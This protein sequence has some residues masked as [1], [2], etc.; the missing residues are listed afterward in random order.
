MSRTGSRLRPSRHM[1]HAVELMQTDATRDL[2][3]APALLAGC[4]VPDGGPGGRRGG[5]RPG[6][7]AALVHGRRDECRRFQGVPD[8]H[9]DTTRHRPAPAHQGETGELRGRVAPGTHPD[10]SRHV[11]HDRPRRAVVHA[12][13]LSMAMLVVL[14]TLSPLERAVFILRE[15][16]GYG[17]AEIAETIGRSEVAVRQLGGS[18]RGDTSMRGDPDSRRTPSSCAMSP[19]GSWSPA[20]RVTSRP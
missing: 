17:H 7:M 15:A 19:S 5:H 8:P 4:G 13:M 2:R 14:E 6:G 3:T 10:R 16:F 20:E 12:E 11:G 9:H 18:G 1:S